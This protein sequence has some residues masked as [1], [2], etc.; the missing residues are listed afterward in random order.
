M[1]LQAQAKDSK[2]ARSCSSDGPLLSFVFVVMAVVLLLPVLL[3]PPPPP[4]L[5]L[6]L[7]SCCFC[8]SATTDA[9][10]AAVAGHAAGPV[11]PLI[12]ILMST[13]A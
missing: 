10:T 8:C 4:P 11:R 9:V 7:N 12:M 2:T 1:V 6:L 13:A 5:L 3:L